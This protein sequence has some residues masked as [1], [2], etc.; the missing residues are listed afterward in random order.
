LHA[1]AANR[2]PADGLL[3]GDIVEALPE[4]IGGIR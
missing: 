2:M 1:A 4:A 3:A